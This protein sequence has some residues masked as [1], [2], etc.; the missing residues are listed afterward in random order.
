[1]RLTE[2]RAPLCHT[3]FLQERAED[4]FDA[5]ILEDTE[6]LA[7]SGAPQRR[8]DFHAVQH[9]F[10]VVLPQFKP[11]HHAFYPALCV[12]AL[13]YRQVGHFFQHLRE[14]KG[15]KLLADKGELE[16]KD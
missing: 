14:I 10:F 1:M 16:G 2:Q 8:T 12:I 4:A 13:P 7:Q 3:V 5:L 6:V 15:E 11:G 9:L